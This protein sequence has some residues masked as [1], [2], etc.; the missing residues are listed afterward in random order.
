VTASVGSQE[1]L[2]VSTRR[3]FV[4]VFDL[5]QLLWESGDAADVCVCVASRGR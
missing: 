1:P 3:C 4:C 5:G 2:V